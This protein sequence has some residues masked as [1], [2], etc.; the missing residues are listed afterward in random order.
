M[1][2]ISTNNLTLTAI[3]LIIN[4]TYSQ[5][6]LSGNVK[7]N[8]SNNI[9]NA[10]VIIFNADTSF[11]KE[12]RTM[13]T[14]NF[15]LTNI[16]ADN[17]T[18][19]ITALGKEYKTGIVNVS[20]NQTNLNYTLN[21]ESNKGVW[22]ILMDS[23]E[24]LGG[25]DLGVML[26]NGKIFYCHNS[27]DP[28]L[29]NPDS[30]TVSYPTGDVQI[31]GCAAAT[32][33]P[34]GRMIYAGGTLQAVYGPGTNKVKAYNPAL[35]IWQ[36]ESDM[37]G[38]RWYPTM[39][40]LPNEKLLIVGGG[41]QN[42]PKR[43]NS[44]EIY[45]PI[46]NTS[47]ATDTV[48]LGNE[49][50]PVISLYNGKVLMTH[51]PPQLFDIPSKQWSLTGDFVQ[52][53]R[54]PNGDHA[55]HE[56]TLLP[57]CDG[58]VI[59]IGYKSFNSGVVGNL[60]EIYNPATQQW[61]LGANYAP[62]RS[63]CK[64]ILLPDKKILVLG[65]YKEESTDP[66]NV[67]AWGYMALADMYDPASNSWR[68][69]N[70]MNYAR[71]YHTIATL[72]ADGRIIVVGGEGQ[73][74]NEP[75]KSI[76]EEFKPPYWFKGVRPELKNISQTIITRGGQITFD[77]EKTNA[78][79]SVILMTL[80]AVTHFMHSDPMRYVELKFTQQG[81]QI[82]VSI[83]SDSLIIPSG[84]YFITAMVDDIPAISTIIK[85]NGTS[86][87]SISPSCGTLM[88]IE[89]TETNVNS[90]PYPM[91]VQSGENVKINF[92]NN[93]EGEIIIIIRWTDI[94]GKLI[95]DRIIHSNG[96]L[97]E[98]NCNVPVLNKGIYFIQ[99]ITNSYGLTKKVIVN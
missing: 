73:P 78:P 93:I 92:K 30:N 72:T 42:N 59:S 2:K 39:L 32:L 10:R 83:P 14:G 53:N 75:P 24:P 79:T 46:L 77:I 80:P 60:T 82:T 23:P 95:E 40:L 81:Q 65:G 54:M 5:F 44:S 87:K 94:T 56:L 33:L 12:Q 86:S 18:I 71:E 61:S 45:D 67:N 43:T 47:V 25:T 38:Y 50:S 34:D 55:D 57:Y 66:T 64:S 90:L 68:R 69:L 21:A 98:I 49:V 11:F 17:Y 13:S 51:R 1:I 89:E 62:V 37:I 7:D 41:N 74:G 36:S 76:I 26:G 6:T 16:P 20:S 63:R 22:N 3:I 97:N 48:A 52:G 8:S 29:F 9:N 99:I 27:Q 96:N 58:R 15:T 88:A 28:F 85:I 70:P 91:P 35:N 19:G 84:F 4:N 31:Q